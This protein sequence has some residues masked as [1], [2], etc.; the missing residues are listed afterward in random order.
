MLNNQTCVTCLNQ[1]DCHKGVRKGIYFE[2]FSPVVKLTTVRFLLAIAVSSG[3]FLHQLDVDNAFLHGDLHEEVY[4]RPPPGFQDSSSKMVCRLHKSLYGLRQAS[5]QWNA[6]LTDALVAFGF[7]QSTTDH[8]LFTHRQNQSFTALLVYV[9]DVVLT[10]NDLT[11]IIE[12]KQYLHHHFRI[13]DI[14]ELKYF[15]GFEVARSHR[16]LVLNQRKYCLEI[17]SEFGLTACK[18]VDTPSTPTVKLNPDTGDLLDDPTS[19][20]RLIGKLIY[21]TNTRPD[22]S[23][24]VQQV[25]QHMSQPRQPH[26]QAAL[27]ILKYLKN[28]P[29]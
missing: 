19:F 20:R 5:R 7:I 23:F 14:G 29:G 12:V 17:L 8:S 15:L 16:G 22:I 11:L 24:V 21:L 18:P 1:E 13:K 4:M 27:R 28:A 2:T 10:G 3:W 6:K 26:L 9:D 25:S